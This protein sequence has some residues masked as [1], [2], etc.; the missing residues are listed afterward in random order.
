M[1]DINTR[2]SES[3]MLCKGINSLLANKAFELDDRK[4]IAVGSLSTSIEYHAALWLLCRHKRFGAAANLLRSQFESYV[5]GVWFLYCS[6]DENVESAYDDA[7]KIGFKRIVSE[8]VSENIPGWEDI[9]EIKVSFWPILCGYT[10]TGKHQLARRF[11]GTNISPNYDDDFVT[12]MLNFG[13]LIAFRSLLELLKV[14][15]SG[16]SEVEL[17]NLIISNSFLRDALRL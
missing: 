9:K 13:D 2:I 8:A 6:S 15:K 5:K 11:R 12:S 1:N 4:T 10:H 17:R 7:L 16:D 3:E 14:S